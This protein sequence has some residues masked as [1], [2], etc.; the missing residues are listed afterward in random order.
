MHTETSNLQRTPS[1][2]DIVQPLCL[3]KSYLQTVTVNIQAVR[4]PVIYGSS[5]VS[6]VFPGTFLN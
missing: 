6:S 1:S 2:S 5:Q 3:R 4:L